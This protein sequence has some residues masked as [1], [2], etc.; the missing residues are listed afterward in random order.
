MFRN[1]SP[2]ALSGILIVGLTAAGASTA[3]P[4]LAQANPGADAFRRAWAYDQGI[5]SPINIPEAIR[6]YGEAAAAGHPLANAR[7]AYIYYAGN[8]VAPDKRT[9]ERYAKGTF[10]GVLKAAEKHDPV[11]ELL[12][13]LMYND[14]LDVARDEDEGLRWLRAAADQGLPLAQ[15]DLGVAYEHGYGV[16]RDSVTAAQWYR[17][18]ADQDNALAQAFLA[19]FYSRGQGVPRDQAEAVRLYQLSAAKNFAHAQTNLGYLYEHG[20]GVE[21]NP[22][23][24]A[25]LY[26]LAARQGFEVAEANLGAMYESGCGVAQDLNLAVQWYRMAAAQGNQNAIKALR[27]YGIEG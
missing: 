27:C 9:A 3:T 13:S 25:R 22:A 1:A 26:W 5:G 24:A 2:Y 14:G 23:E 19:D 16:P 7:L 17:R 15:A 6:L 21:C 11:A 20:C 10:A 12:A 18:A 4:D 8:G